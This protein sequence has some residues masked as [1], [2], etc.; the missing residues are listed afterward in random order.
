MKKLREFLNQ[1][2]SLLDH[3]T[4]RWILIVFNVF[5]II[6]FVN[7]FVPLISTG[8]VTIQDLRSSYDFPDSD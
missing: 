2:F 4:H 6:F 5:F 8:G 3:V 1:P 7:V